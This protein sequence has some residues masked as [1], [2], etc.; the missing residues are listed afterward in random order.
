MLST[1][2]PLTL[3]V[4]SYGSPT[5]PLGSAASVVKCTRSDTLIVRVC[6]DF[7]PEAFAART[8]NVYAFAE[9]ALWSIAVSA[10]VPEIFPVEASRDK[11]AGRS[12]LVMLHDVAVPASVMSW[13]YASPI[14]AFFSEVVVIFTGSA[15]S[16]T[17]S[18]F[19]Y[20][21][22]VRFRST[23]LSLLSVI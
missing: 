21:F 10:T 6:D 7:P 22:S 23:Y 17:V 11:P 15:G 5:L 12:P 18:S 3:I 2:V 9:A 14:R 16:G 4:A 8:V 13:L 1:A 20:T 19:P